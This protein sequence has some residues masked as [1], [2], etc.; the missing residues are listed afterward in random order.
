MAKCHDFKNGDVVFFRPEYV[1]PNDDPRQAFAIVNSHPESE[2]IDVKPVYLDAK[3]RGLIIPT[4][5]YHH[6]YFMKVD[7]QL[8]EKIEGESS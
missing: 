2:A 3:K 8:E 6:R 5:T 4:G 1:G 7:C